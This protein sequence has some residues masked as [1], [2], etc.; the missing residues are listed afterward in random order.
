MLEKVFKLIVCFIIG[1]GLGLTVGG[2]TK[3]KQE[4]K[5]IKVISMPQEQQKVIDYITTYYKHIPPIVVDEIAKNVDKASTKYDIQIP[6]IMGVIEKESR[7][8]ASAVSSKGA[9][10]LMQVMP[11]WT[12]ELSIKTKHDLH[13]I[14]TNINA[15][16]H[17][18]KK[19]LKK[20]N[21]N[22]EKALHKYLGEK[23]ID[24]VQD[25]FK[26]IS[27]YTAFKIKQ[28]DPEID[29]PITQ[30]TFTH[31]I[32]YKGEMLGT[33]AQWYTGSVNNWPKIAKANININPLSLQIGDKIIIPVTLLKKTSVM[34]KTFINQGE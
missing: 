5:T 23:D 30:T 19:Y 6:I 2:Y 26:N 9:R 34:P 3:H 12:K 13:C 28:H 21:F 18:L 27:I 17:I 10:G 25:V 20:S 24:Y 32:K 1:L 14:T 8:N 15:G 16:T 33:I 11:F 22:L 31:T 4:P 7:F 29:I